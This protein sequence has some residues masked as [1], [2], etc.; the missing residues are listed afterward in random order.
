MSRTIR[1][2]LAEVFINGMQRVTRGDGPPTSF[3]SV[4]QA[5]VIAGPASSVYGPTA[6]TG[7]YVNLVTKQPFFDAFHSDTE[8]TYGSYDEMIWTEDFG[9]PIIKNE[10]AYRVSYQGDYSGSYYNNEKTN[11]NDGFVALAWTPS[12]GFRVDFN[13]EIYDG[14]YQEN[15]G[16][17]RPTQGFINSGQ[18]NTGG[19]VPFAGTAAGGTGVVAPVPGGASGGGYAG[20]INSGGTVGISKQDTLISPNDSDFGKDINAELAV[21]YNVNDGLSLINHTYYEYYEIRNAGLAQLY[22]DVQRTNMVENRTQ[23]HIDFDTPVGDDPGDTNKSSTS[24]SSGSDSKDMKNMSE[25]QQPLIFKNDIITGVAFKYLGN[26]GEGDFFNEYL[27]A[28]D[29]STG[30]FPNVGDQSFANTFPIAGTNLRAT[31][32]SLTTD[33]TAYEASAFYQHQITFTPQWTLLYSGRADAIF[34]RLK[35][36][37]APEGDGNSPTDYETTSQV[38]GTGDVSIDYK[39]V[40]WATTY[41]TFDFNESYAGN[42]GGGIDSFTNGGQSVDYHYKNFL[43]EGGAKFDLMDHPA[44]SRRW[45]GIIRCT[46]SPM[47][48]VRLRKFAPWVQRYR[49]HFSRRVIFT[50]SSTSLI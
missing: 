24:S 8:F 38:L 34:D 3:N 6:N 49:R 45:M 18:Y 33:E 47:P 11:T 42:K 13:A 37:L 41:L 10:L 16:I 20:L 27:N 9:A 15:T 36:P 35:D 14:R 25:I 21:T 19:A 29:I 43:Y 46:T 23:V 5:D 30:T 17:N 48:S 4:E 39:P 44:F 28:T 2:Q 26:Y 22:T 1:G 7:G 31:S 50:S 32:N 12:T 40:R